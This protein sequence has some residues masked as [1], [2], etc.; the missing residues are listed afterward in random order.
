MVAETEQKPDNGVKDVGGGNQGDWRSK[1]TGRRKRQHY[2]VYLSDDEAQFLRRLAEAHNKS[3]SAIV[4]ACVRHVMAE[5]NMRES[6]VGAMIR[7][8]EGR[9]NSR[10]LMDITR[11]L[12]EKKSNG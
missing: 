9:I 1:V 6:G 2:D 7:S 11:V 10:M 12:G 4:R 3:F 8:S 5:H